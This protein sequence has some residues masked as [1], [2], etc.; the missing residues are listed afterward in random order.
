MRSSFLKISLSK[1]STVLFAVAK[2]KNLIENKIYNISCKNGCPIAGYIY[3]S[4]RD[5][6]SIACNGIVEL[7]SIPCSLSATIDNCLDWN[8]RIPMPDKL[9]KKHMSSIQKKAFKKFVSKFDENYTIHFVQMI[10][11][12]IM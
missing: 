7:G 1:E 11:P 2:H 6:Y 4:Q 8:I 10:D 9:I 3:D 5:E 12:N